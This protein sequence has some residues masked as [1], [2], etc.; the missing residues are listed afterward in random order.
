M[1]QESPKTGPR[2]AQDGPKSAQERPKS[3]PRG[4]QD[5]LFG[6]PMG[7]SELT[8][9]SFFG[10]GLQ[11]GP[12]RPLRFPKRAPRGPQDPPKE[13]HSSKKASDAPR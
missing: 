2:E 3:G 7:R 5:A 8:P 11:D 10:R 6:R 12:K 1:A 9:P 13:P 4:A